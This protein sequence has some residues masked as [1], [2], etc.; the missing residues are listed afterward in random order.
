MVYNTQIRIA[1]ADDHAVYKE[2]IEIVLNL[3]P[4]MKV[5]IKANNGADLL[6]KIK[7]NEPDVVLLDLR[8]PVMDG[9]TTLVEL[10]KHHPNVKVIML[11]LTSDCS[12][13]NDARK[14][15]AN[16][17]L[18]K[19]SDSGTITSTIREVILHNS[20]QRNPGLGGS[21]NSLN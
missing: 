11:T 1:I 7:D 5:V 6:D 4:D 8:M 20:I 12:I 10:H 3:Y 13:E 21:K 14:L 18:S 2:G 17:Y 19:S 16:A 15:G 9:L